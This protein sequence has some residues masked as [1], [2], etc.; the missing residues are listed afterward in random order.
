[1]MPIKSSNLTLSQQKEAQAVIDDTAENALKAA[2]TYKDQNGGVLTLN[3][4]NVRYNAIDK[5][6]RRDQQPDH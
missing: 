6:H 4:Q 5:R 1:M 3:E 2:E